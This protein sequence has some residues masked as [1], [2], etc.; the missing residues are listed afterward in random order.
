L[1][2]FYAWPVLIPESLPV[3]NIPDGFS[4]FGEDL[5]KISLTFGFN[6]FSF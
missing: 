4:I 3:K 5:L 6:G 2:I 1:K